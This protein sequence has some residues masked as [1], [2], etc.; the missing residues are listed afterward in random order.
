ME[1]AGDRWKQGNA[2]E[3]STIR[4]EA[5]PAFGPASCDEEYSG[6]LHVKGT[7]TDLTFSMTDHLRDELNQSSVKVC[8]LSFKVSKSHSILCT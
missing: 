1:K 5:E 3:E 7:Q 8:S 4:N 2:R 6:N